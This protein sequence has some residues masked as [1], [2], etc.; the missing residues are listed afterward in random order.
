MLEWSTYLGG[1]VDDEINAIASDPAG[2]VYVAGRTASRDLAPAGA[3]DGWDE[4]NAICDD[5]PPCYDAFVAKYAPGGSLVHI[6]YL[7]GRR[8]EA[9]Q[10][11]AADNAGNTYVA[12]FTNSPNFPIHSAFQPDWRCGFV[13]GDAFVTKLSPSGAVL[14]YST[15]LGGCGSFGDVARGIA[16][17][18]QGRA[19]VA[20]RD[21]RLR[22]PHN[23]WRR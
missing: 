8:D 12:G 19:V 9:A 18:A 17:D 21:G 15:Y 4:R 7:S 5:F 23:P 20:G 16:V 6:S 10:A 2:N 3:L 22:L 13:Y 11:I 14:G 1:G